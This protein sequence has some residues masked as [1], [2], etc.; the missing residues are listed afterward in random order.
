[1]TAELTPVERYGSWWAK[2][3]D[4]A[5]DQGL[6][7]PSGAKM[8]QFTAMASKA[9]KGTPMIV[10][11]SAS[12]AMQVYVAAAARDFGTKAIVYIPARKVKTPATLW[13]EW[14]GAEINP[15]PHGYP[16]VYRKAARERAKLEGGCIRWDMRLAV[17]DTA[18]QC[19][20]LPPSV[21]RVVVP[22]GSGATAAGILVGLRRM[23]CWDVSILAI[24]V[25]NL[26]QGAQKI[27]DM[28][29]KFMSVP[30]GT[31]LGLIKIPKAPKFERDCRVE[32]ATH[33]LSYDKPVEAS[34]PNTDPLDPYYAAK[35]L[36]RLETGDCLWVSGRRALS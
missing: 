14:Y 21:R 10:G 36:A 16:S 4:F 22:T 15:L 28:A 11:C 2:R 23:K 25:S 18:A 19:A 3:E 13:A 12:S 6:A 27:I 32:I 1:M 33:P 9:P 26:V 24:C 29:D 17:E 7:W 20:N 5:C 8:R 34:L 31:G 35:A 30:E